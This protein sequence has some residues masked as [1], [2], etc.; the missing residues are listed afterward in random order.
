MQQTGIITYDIAKN[1]QYS[2]I[3]KAIQE[4]E[5]YSDRRKSRLE[6]GRHTFRNVVK[7]RYLTDEEIPSEMNKLADSSKNEDYE[8]EDFKKANVYSTEDKFATPKKAWEQHEKQDY[9]SFDNDS[10]GYDNAQ[11]NNLVRRIKKGEIEYDRCPPTDTR[12]RHLE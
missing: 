11:S 12:A 7:K 10:E 3:I 8:T 4:T 1:P 2:H 9:L 6:R 5:I